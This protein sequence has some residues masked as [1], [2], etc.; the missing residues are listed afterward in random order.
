MERSLGFPG[1]EVCKLSFA[2]KVSA[3]FCSNSLI[4]EVF[5]SWIDFKSVSVVCDTISVTVAVDSEVVAIDQDID[6]CLIVN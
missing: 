2:E 1:R 4:A 3:S 5:P 6:K